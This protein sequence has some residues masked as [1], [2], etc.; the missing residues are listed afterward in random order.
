MTPRDIA[1]AACQ[2]AGA[3]VVLVAAVLLLGV[4]GAVL[5]CGSVL[6]LLGAALQS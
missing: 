5:W 2:L 1:A 6:Y 4:A 3:L